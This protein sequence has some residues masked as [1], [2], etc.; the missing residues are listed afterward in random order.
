MIASA[1]ELGEGQTEHRKN[2][3]FL[4]K[5]QATSPGCGLKKRVCL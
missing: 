1:E 4:F 2:V 5:C 3:L